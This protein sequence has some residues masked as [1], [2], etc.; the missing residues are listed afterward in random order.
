M[1]VSGCGKSWRREQEEVSRRGV[2][3]RIEGKKSGL[4]RGEKGQKQ[5]DR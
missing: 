2:G 3:G 5:K 4:E 1:G